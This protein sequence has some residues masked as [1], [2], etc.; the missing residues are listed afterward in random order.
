MTIVKTQKIYFK[1]YL[2]GESKNIEIST[3]MCRGFPSTK[4]IGLPSQFARALIEKVNLAL[5]S[6]GYKLPQQKVRIC[7]KNQEGNIQENKHITNYVYS[8][9][10]PI[11]LSILLCSEQIYF[12][13]FLLH[14][15]KSEDHSEENIEND[16]K[17]SNIAQKPRKN[18]FF[19][20]GSL[21]FDA[22]IS[23]FTEILPYIDIHEEKSGTFKVKNPCY[24]NVGYQ[25]III[26]PNDSIEFVR[27][28]RK[29]GYSVQKKDSSQSYIFIDSLID[30]Q[31]KIDNHIDDFSALNNQSDFQR[32]KATSSQIFSTSNNSN[33]K[34]DR[35]NIYDT[36]YAFST[37]NVSSSIKTVKYPNNLLKKDNL[38]TNNDLTTL[39]YII[40]QENAK[41]TCIIAASGRHHILFIGPIGSSKTLLAHAISEISPLLSLYE[42]IELSKYH[43]DLKNQIESV[44]INSYTLNS[45]GH[46]DHDDNYFSFARPFIEVMRNTTIP[47]LFGSKNQQGLLEQADMGFLLIDE[48]SEISS[49]VLNSLKTSL[50]YRQ[51]KSPFRMNA[52][53]YDIISPSRYTLI[54]TSNICPCGK[55]NKECKCKLSEKINFIK[56]IPESII[57]RIDILSRVSLTNFAKNNQYETNI[58]EDYKLSSSIN[59]DLHDLT[60]YKR[61]VKDATEIQ[62]NRFRNEEY[63]T[64]SEI[65]LDKIEKF[66]TCTSNASKTLNS[67]IERLGL[68]G[69]DY[70]K[71][72][73]IAR[74]I[75]DLDFKENINEEHIFEALSY[76]TTSLRTE[77]SF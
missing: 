63:K 58:K 60:D 28:L 1:K 3:A 50:D 67:S 15:D 68:N 11:A 16:E 37:H 42:Q 71:V 23:G 39:N 66:C 45:K 20:G 30:I 40:G 22:H 54:A 76:R 19:V 59:Q 25:D 74:T 33:D 73:K 9:E 18:M 44:F 8:L 41:R 21:N 29:Q 27:L 51:I 32:G 62:K 6:A 72:L 69:R 35:K 53:N 77:V 10:L 46:Y 49:A 64:N 38:I 56:K 13:D 31:G 43:Q 34:S 75:A 61:I 5:K 4:I 52:S 17:F 55:D 24:N 2:F 47:N 12:P 70:I 7:I 14:Q 65:P 57:N 48:I 26:L 36:N